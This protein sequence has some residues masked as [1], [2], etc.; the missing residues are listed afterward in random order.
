MRLTLDNIDDAARRIAGCLQVGDAVGLS[1]DL[2]AGKTTLVR[3]LLRVFGLAGE[4][5]S[6]SFAIVQPYGAPEVTMPILH[7]DLYRIIDPADSIELG[8]DEGR[9]DHLLFVEW[10]ERMGSYQWDDMLLLDLQVQ[11]DE[12]RLL[13]AK[14]PPAWKERWPFPI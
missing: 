10:P 1:G 3:A 8:L 6:P 11:S 4:A 5:P 7:V 9:S 12:T 14:A 2:G 13:T